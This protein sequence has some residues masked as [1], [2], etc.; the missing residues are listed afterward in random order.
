MLTIIFII[1][2][3]WLAWK[4]LILEIRAA[5][6]IAKIFC[7]TLLFPLF[8]L[9]MVCAGLLYIAVPILMIAGII[10]LI[11]GAIDA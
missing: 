9:G 10:V 2:L 3:I 5:W 1:A 4:M 8:L 11:R 6:G 7:T